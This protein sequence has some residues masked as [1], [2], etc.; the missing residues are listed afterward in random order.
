[1]IPDP[2]NTFHT[3]LAPCYG[4]L[5]RGGGLDLQDKE[6]ITT[7]S[8]TTKIIGRIA[9]EERTWN[10]IVAALQ[11]NPVLQPM[12]NE[13]HRTAEYSL[14]GFTLLAGDGTPDQIAMNK[15]WFPSV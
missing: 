15:V 13:I 14:K 3:G 9:P 6:L 12:G 5:K 7:I 4:T 11:Q 1:M 8:V 10:V 2:S